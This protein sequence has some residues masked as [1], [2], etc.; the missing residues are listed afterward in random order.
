ME[1]EKSVELINTDKEVPKQEFIEDRLLLLT[2]SI[3]EKFRQTDHPADCM[4]L[5][6]HY[7]YTAKW[8]KTNVTHSTTAYS[9]KALKWSLDRVRKT[10]KVLLDLG[11][12]ED[13]T[14]KSQKGKIIG[15]YIKIR[16]IFKKDTVKNLVIDREENHTMEN[17]RGGKTHSVE[18]PEPNALSTSNVNALSTS[19]Q[20]LKVETTKQE[21][22]ERKRE[23][24]TSLVP[25]ST[26]SSHSLKEYKRNTKKTYTKYKSKKVKDIIEDDEDWD[27]G[28]KILLK[29]FSESL[30]DPTR[31]KYRDMVTLQELFMDSKFDF[32]AYCKWYKETKYPT[33]SFNWGLFMYPAIIDEFNLQYEDESRYL[34]TSTNLRNSESFQKGVKKTKEWIRQLL[35]EDK[36]KKE[37][38]KR[39]KEKEN[40]EKSV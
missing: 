22:K 8:Q 29:Y 3:Y 24:R 32:K 37:A 2:A 13:I 25:S 14:R 1:N 5:Y 23:K 20:T 30:I 21:R 16:Y 15:H 18:N 28:Y 10:K 31:L 26:S 38:T 19:T 7:Y 9:A 6:I 11:L 12:I 17:P 34:K 40:A 33:K 35:A 4:A 27:R 39:K 36:K